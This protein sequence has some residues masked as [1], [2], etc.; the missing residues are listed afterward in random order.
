MH[1]MSSSCD[2]KEAGHKLA[3]ITREEQGKIKSRKKD[4]DRKERGKQLVAE[5]NFMTW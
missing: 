4:F 3:V 1:E 2:G 5:K